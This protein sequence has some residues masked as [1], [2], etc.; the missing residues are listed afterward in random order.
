MCFDIAATWVDSPRVL[1]GCLDKDSR[2]VP[3]HIDAKITVEQCLEHLA[4]GKRAAV[5]NLDLEAAHRLLK[6]TGVAHEVGERFAEIHGRVYIRRGSS[7]VHNVL[8]AIAWFLLQP[9]GGKKGG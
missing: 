4:P 1:I 7:R 9:R 2:F 6:R 3:G 8:Q 5:I